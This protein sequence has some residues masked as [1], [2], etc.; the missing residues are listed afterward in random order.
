M[1]LLNALMDSASGICWVMLGQPAQAPRLFRREIDTGVENCSK[2]DS[3]V[4]LEAPVGGQ[5]HH[6]A[7]SDVFIGSEA[8]ARGNLT[9][10][11]LRYRHRRIFHDVYVP[12]AHEPSLRDRTTGAWLWSRRQAIVAGIA[13]SALHGANWVDA[14]VPIE[15]IAPNARRQA[16]VVVRNE[17]LADDEITHVAR[18]TVTT[19]ARTAYDLGRHLSRAQAVARMDALMHATPF[20]V[21]DVLLLAK[22]YSGAR[23]LRRLRAA[24]PYIDGGAASP[25]ETW[26]RLLLIDAGLP[27][28]TTQIPVFDGYTPIALLDMG[29]EEFKVAAEYDGDQHRSDRRQYVKDIRR[30]EV[31]RD[32]GW[33]VVRVVSEDRPRDVVERVHRALVERGYR[34]ERHQSRKAGQIQR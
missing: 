22:R 2:L 32:R 3:P 16:G 27:V 20:S 17:T 7:M 10:S 12:K 19:P 29:W 26:L 28:P 34:P 13:A 21:E 25:K 5:R 23:G 15:L 8:V 6:A 9:K 30:H 31:V 18:L 14:N 1:V 11:D 4:D 24:L 33:H